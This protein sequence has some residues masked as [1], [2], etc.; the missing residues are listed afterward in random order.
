MPTDRRRFL[1]TA[2]LSLAAGASSAAQESILRRSSDASASRP[3]GKP[4]A[5]EPDLST[6]DAVRA[7]FDLARGYVQLSQF[8]LVSH[9]RP[10]REEVDRIRRELDAQPFLTVEHGL[11]DRPRQVREAAAVY[12]GGRPEEVALTTNTTTGLAI[13]YNGLPL[14]A[15]DE[16]LTTTHDHYSHLESLRLAA[17]RAHASVR[18]VT[19]YDDSAAASEDEIVERLRRA[20][21]PATR[22]VGVTWVHSCTGV[23]LP[24]RRIGQAIAEAN[25]GRAEADKVLLVVDGVHG[26]GVEDEAVAGMGC[27]FF[28]AGTHKWIL[29]PRGT[30]LVWGRASSW[31]LTRP[32][33]P[34][35]EQPPY[36]AWMTGRPQGPV[37]A[38]WLTPGGFQAYEHQWAL[39]TA[40]D[41]HRRIGRARIAER[42]HALN[43]QCKEGLATMPHVTLKTPRGSRLSAGIICFEVK[44]LKPE[45]VV[46]RLLEKR[47]VASASPYLVSYPRLAPSLVNTPEEVETA[48]AAVRSLA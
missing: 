13:V 14:K 6:W 29:G 23:K 44:G 17:E 48:L 10:V 7:Q 32:T 9:P 4:L 18:K 24:I 45:E 16:I 37:S 1:V 27:D 26:F 25:R 46:A 47:V 2:G 34:A 28:S 11:F 36:F 22:V 35:F 33:I 12:L 8:Y 3:R 5:A 38:S 15:G 42:I 43:D 20:I 39:P 31:A 19:L 41:F 30:G 40:F 21:R